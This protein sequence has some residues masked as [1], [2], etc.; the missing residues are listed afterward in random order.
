MPILMLNEF[1]E[2]D[3]FRITVQHLEVCRELILDG[4]E[5]KC[6]SALIL[7]DHVCEV[8]LFR[9]INEEYARDDYVRSVTPEL[10]PPKETP[11]D[12]EILSFEAPST[13]RDP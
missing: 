2:L 12:K 4:G 11:A 1:D 3:Q 9:I 6:R 7:L 8:I 13:C 5:A 10:Y